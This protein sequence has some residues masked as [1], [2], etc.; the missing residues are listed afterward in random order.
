[1]PTANATDQRA[2]FDRLLAAARMRRAYSCVRGSIST[3]SPVGAS[4]SAATLRPHLP[5]FQAIL[6][7]RE[8]IRRD[9]AWDRTGLGALTL[10]GL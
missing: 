10:L 3:S 8:R 4:T 1:M 7:T 6:R 5:R 2:P 9:L